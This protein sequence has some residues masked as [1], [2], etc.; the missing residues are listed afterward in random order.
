M[1]VY[2]TASTTAD[3]KGIL[4]LQKQ[5]LPENITSEERE[6][7]GFVTVNHDF[8]LLKKL[9]D[10][11]PHIIVK[12]GEKVIAY[13]LAMTQKFRND[14]PILIPMFAIFDK[15]RYK[16]KPISDYHYMLVG[17]VCVDKEYRGQNVF[18]KIYKT[19]RNTYY[20]EYDFAITEVAESNP[21]SLRA[22]EKVGFKPVHS[23]FSPDG[24]K[25]IIV[26]WDWK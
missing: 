8:E 22:H 1:I 4:Q 14:I 3:L 17:Q 15:T 21:R 16:G 23:Y 12:F 9:H 24:T 11:H 6:N 10:S 7:Q 13:V 25:W 26:I 18:S 20:K 2:Q 19:Y 5:N